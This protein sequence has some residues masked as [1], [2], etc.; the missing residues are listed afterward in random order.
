MTD[1][2]AEMS[3]R[4][5]I[6]RCLRA[7]D[8]RDYEQ[9]ASGFA[10]DGVWSR[11]GEDL[12]GPAAVREA[13]EKRPADFETQH[14]VLNLVVDLEGIDSATV[15][16]TIAGYAQTADKPYHLH[17]M[18]RATDRLKRTA[19]GWRF[20]HRAAVPAFSEQA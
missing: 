7:L 2:E 3:C 6:I 15:R 12:V 8:D 17:A 16:Y 1:I 20:V 14:L 9:L 18:F 11:G 5:F 13:M 4:D 10:E 19:G